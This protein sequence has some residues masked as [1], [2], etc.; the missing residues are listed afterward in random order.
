VN[1]PTPLPRASHLNKGTSVAHE[2]LPWPDHAGTV[3][4]HQK[5]HLEHD[6]RP[7]VTNLGGLV[8]PLALL[9]RLKAAEV[10]DDRVEVF[11]IHLPY[12]ESDHVLCQ[13]LMLYAGGTCL[14]DMALLQQDPAVL[15]MLGAERTPDPTTSGDFLRRFERG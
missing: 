9:R 11:K 12:H 7:D 6:A 4:R 3:L 5:L 2:H 13:A 1:K 8:F 10:I 15:K 14:E